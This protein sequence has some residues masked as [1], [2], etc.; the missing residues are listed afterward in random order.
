MKSPKVLYQDE[1]IIILNKPAGWVVNR[2]QTVKQKTIQDWLEEN[3][4]FPIFKEKIFRSGVVHRL[5]KE[6][7]GI[8]LIA[9]TPFSFLELQKQFKERKVKK[10]YFALVH[11]LVIPKEGSV[12]APISRSPFDRK[13]FGV[14]LG[15]REAETNFKVLD[16]FKD[17]KNNYFTFLEVEPKT[18]RTHQ[19]R[20]HLKYLGYPI[21]SD[22][23]YAGRK[24]VREDRKWC[25]RLFLQ[26][27]FLSFVHPTQKNKIEIK[28][29]L[30]SE[31]K[32]ILKKLQKINEREIEN[33]K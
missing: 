9:K 2:A 33:Q 26:A 6:T 18:G 25:S 29:P 7:S 13:K 22:S 14:F 30:E 5:D 21:V 10:K 3:F 32:E 27:Y 8:L 12:K 24:T 15:G 20:V 17:E 31:L 19:I 28:L 23:F 11:G 1:E 16:Y 4:S